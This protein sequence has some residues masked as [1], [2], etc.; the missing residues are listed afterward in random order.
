MKSVDYL[1]AVV[2][3]HNLKNA[4]KLAEHLGIAT[5]SVS[6]YLAGKRIMNN[7]ACLR[8]AA[9]LGM[10]NPFPIIMAADIERAEKVGERSFWEKFRRTAT[11]TVAASE[12]Q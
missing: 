2:D 1:K 6:Q 8:V 11:A 9:A 12:K 3:Q 7:E 5:N 4:S 10:E